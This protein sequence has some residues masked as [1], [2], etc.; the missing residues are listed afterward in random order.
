VLQLED[1]HPHPMSAW[2]LDEVHTTHS[3]LRG[4]QTSLVESGPARLVFEVTHQVRSSKIKQSIIF[5]RDLSRVDFRT[6]LDWQEL[7]SP[8][9]G[10]PNLKAAFTA[11]LL[12]TQAWYETPFAAVQRPGDGLEVPAL[13]W[14]DVGGPEYGIALLND[15]KYGYDALGA[16]LRLTLVRSGYDPDAISDVGQHDINYS[17]LA[18]PGDWRAANVVRHAAGYNQ[19]LLA[20]QVKDGAASTPGVRFEI[21][22]APSVVPA[23]VKWAY[24][25]SG[26][27][28][29]LYESAGQAV[30]A[31]VCGVPAGARAWETTIA[32]DRLRECAVVNGRVRLAFRPWQIIT[33]L[34]E[35]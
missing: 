7:G 10:V 11:H 34:F 6:T 35:D 27:V 12:E 13:R 28:L 26:Q 24:K 9:A 18:H 16:R 15:S 1:E 8:E 3:L 32:E 4:A 29:R 22:G 21:D 33:L 5:Y 14:A 25:G 2:H 31:E 19:P 17:L 30:E 23:C 20:R